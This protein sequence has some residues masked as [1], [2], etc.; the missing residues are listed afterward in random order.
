MHP[1]DLTWLVPLLPLAAFIL[2]FAFGKRLPGQG[3][4]PAIVGMGASAVISIAIA[5]EFLAGGEGAHFHIHKAALWAHAGTMPVSI[6]Y[7]VDPLTVVMLFVVSFVGFWIFVYSIG[8]MHGDPRYSR[9]FSFLALFGAAM[10]GVVV[11]DNFV[12][13]FVCWELVGL[14]SYLLIGFWFE[15]P[16][17]MRA[18]KKAFIVTKLG[19]LGFFIGIMYLVKVAHALDFATL[20]SEHKLEMLGALVC[21]KAAL[22]IFCGAVGKSAQFPLHVWLPDAMEGP[23]PVSALIH[24]ATM[25]AAGVYLV[26]RMYP[27]FHAGEPWALGTVAVIATITAVM[28]ATIAVCANDIKR[29]LAYST[30][31]QLG[32]MMMGL[33]VGAW[34]AGVFHLMTHAFFKALLFLG[35]GSVIHGTGTQDIWEMGGLKKKMPVTFWTFLAGTLALA[36]VFPFAGFFS[37]DEILLGAW[38][39]S[40]SIWIF[41]LIGAFLT[42]FYM[43]RLIYVVFL[44]APKKPEIVGHESPPVMTVPLI[45]LA[46]MS[47]I[48]GWVAFP[49][50]NKF[51]Q[52]VH[53]APGHA[54][55][56]PMAILVGLMGLSLVVALSGIG[57]AWLMYGRNILSPNALKGIA[58]GPARVGRWIYVSLQRKW[59]WDEFWWAVLVVP[60]FAFTKA[61]RAFDTWVIDLLVNAVGQVTVWLSVLHRF[62]DTWIVDGTVNL[63]GEFTKGL[64]NVT[65]RFQT[66]YVQN[67]LL[68]AS[69]GLVVVAWFYLVR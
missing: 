32:Y 57:V 26:A 47:T 54:A 14:T 30:V 43:F 1:S 62:V 8:Y 34:T 17:A 27:L 12:L 68:M 41:G 11:A 53:F 23:T 65:R 52:L 44:G 31:S 10:L 6:G 13:L 56:H 36:G 3:A 46:V 29:I 39:Y 18:A 22:L 38:D 4:Y 60:L 51:H 35:S 9:F 45:V 15:R 28:A 69:I 48:G 58:L 61:A 40:K 19:D 25:V 64:G 16:S 7:L 42:A 37:K 24:A 5:V 33:G 55:E 66:G 67:Y 2:I 20:F 21:G 59:Y 49:G 50:W 63:M